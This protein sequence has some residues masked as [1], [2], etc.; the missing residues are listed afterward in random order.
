MIRLSL[1]SLFVLATAACGLDGEPQE[2]D[3]RIQT[4]PQAGIS[5]SG[6]ARI[7]VVGGF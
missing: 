3:G 5:V 7:G 2:P 6:D 4:A 1:F